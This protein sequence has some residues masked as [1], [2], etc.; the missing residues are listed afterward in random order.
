M[1]WLGQGRPNPCG[2]SPKVLYGSARAR[3]AQP[4]RPF[5]QGSLWVGSGKAGPTPA[6]LPPKGLLMGRLGQGRPNPCGPSP[7]VLYG[8]ARARPA[9]PLRPF[10]Q[11]VFSWVGSGK[12]GPTHAALPPKGLFMGWLGQRPTQ[13]MKRGRCTH[14]RGPYRC[15]LPG[16]A[17]FG[18]CD[19]TAALAEREG[20]EPSVLFPAHTISNR[21]PSATRSPLH[22]A[23]TTF[24]RLARLPGLNAH[25]AEA[26]DNKAPDAGT[27]ACRA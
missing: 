26:S 27:V 19:C 22:G 1:G 21:A 23:S 20:F 5:P 25:D 12:A 7:K 8:S 18:R 4:M 10:P 14:R 9:Q 2:P 13:P 17:E 3:P 6:A 15:S 16:L 11:R 24:L